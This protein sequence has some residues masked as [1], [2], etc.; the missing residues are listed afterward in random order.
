MT[1][2]SLAAYIT[3]LSATKLRRQADKSD[4]D[5]CFPTRLVQVLVSHGILKQ[6]FPKAVGGFGDSYHDFLENILLISTQFSA[7][8]SILTTQVSLGIWPLHHFGTSQQRKKFLTPM[9]NGELWTSFA[10]SEESI[11]NRLT[12]FETTAIEKNDHWLISG[13]KDLVANATIA[14]LFL[15]AA[16]VDLAN[17]THEN[18]I[19]LVPR[20]TPG[21]TVGPTLKKVGLWGF[22]VATLTLDHAQLDKDQILGRKLAGNKQI[23]LI[24]NHLRLAIA[25][26][27]LGI[28]KGAFETSMTYATQERKFGLQLITSQNIQKELAEVGTGYEAIK[29][30]FDQ[31]VSLEVDN[32]VAIAKIKLISSGIALKATDALMQISAGYGQLHDKHI[33][34]YTRDA[35]AITLYGGSDKTQRRHIFKGLMKDMN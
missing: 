5:Q 19:F 20:D 30:Y 1:T 3:E 7:L 15:V 34:R 14:D 11:G 31:V 2:R 24:L 27:G 23:T 6:S 26:K 12:D 25:A 4:E 29:A 18:G 13:T 10:Y 28:A 16:K 9:L 17:G 8:A 22:P 32:T 21:V 33:D 35:E